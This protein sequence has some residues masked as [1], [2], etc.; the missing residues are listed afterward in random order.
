MN[1]FTNGHPRE[2]NAE[3]MGFVRA[4]YMHHADA[5]RK[6]REHTQK[7]YSKRAAGAQK[8]R[9]AGGGKYRRGE[10]RSTRIQL[11][12]FAFARVFSR[13]RPDLDFVGVWLVVAPD[14]IPGLMELIA[15]APRH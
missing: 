7:A 11:S 3:T 13:P 6:A 8:S 15:G 2:N 12:V 14:P 9:Q 5:H 10:E 4:Y 1:V